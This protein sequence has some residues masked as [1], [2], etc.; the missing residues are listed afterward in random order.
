MERAVYIIS[1]GRPAAVERMAPHL[2]TLAVRTP[3]F[4]VTCHEDRQAYL[5]AG[6]S[7]VLATERHLTRQ[8]NLA[9][10]HAFTGAGQDDG[11]P[12]ACTQLDDDLKRLRAKVPGGARNEGVEVELVDVLTAHD[13]ALDDTGLSLVGNSPT[14]NVGFARDGISTRKFVPCPCITVRPSAPRFDENLRLKEDY[15]FT[16]QHWATYGGAAR[17]DFI[18]PSFGRYTNE[19]GAVSYRT[20]ELEQ[21][22]IAYLMEKWPGMVR[23]NP[24]R[25][26]EI[27]LPTPRRH[28]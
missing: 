23:P 20:A 26:N 25:A 11:E 16:L 6:A 24:K 2:A 5:D 18:A 13:E 3:V 17:C 19:G 4:W 12:R 15:D 10:D 28:R 22:T 21:E 14:D 9:L 27:L 7:H 8:R 1:A